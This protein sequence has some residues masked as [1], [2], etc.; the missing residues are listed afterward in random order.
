MY[1][2]ITMKL[3]VYFETYGCALNRADESVMKAILRDKGYEIVEDPK[4]AN[5]IVIN[6]CIVR[7]DTEVRMIKRLRYLAKLGKK[8]IVAGCMA[9]ALPSHV[10]RIVKEAILLAPQ[11]VSR[12][13]EAVE[14][15][16]A[17]M[18]I[19]EEKDIEYIGV[20]VEGVKA[21]IAVGEGCIDDCA[22]CIVKK[23][24]PR[25]K[26]IPIERVVKAVQ[27]ALSRG[28]KEIEITAQD[29]AVYGIDVYG[30]Y[31][32]VDLLN[33]ILELEYD[34][35]LR[36]GQLNPRHLIKYMDEI[37]EVLK[38]P[39]VYKHVHIPLQSGSNKVL[40]VMNRGSTVEE[41]IQIVHELRSKVEGI[42][43][44]TDIIVGH[45]GEDELSFLESVKVIAEYDIDRV[46][47]ARYSIR[48]FTP[49]ASMPQIPD[50]IK[51][52]RSKYIEKVYQLIALSKYLEYVNSYGVAVVTERGL[53]DD[54]FVARLFNYIP[55]VIKAPNALGKTLLIH[56][57]EATFYDLRGE[58]VKEVG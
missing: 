18:F 39:R 26:S 3:K 25:L 24:R 49:A 30:K 50:N 27:E 15:P 47:I 2:E 41:F 43:I 40:T 48:P 28:A 22:F 4:E 8:L 14:A 29:L 20:V 42:H 46:H 45:P 21:V 12:I 17:S 55:V 54:S 35:R 53:H 7:Y 33:A 13:H 1:V 10:R 37:V 11:S 9:R 32:L 6:T 38:D 34:F 5:V 57:K 23:A 56:I 44:A 19:E 52:I 51:K 16:P 31:A 58:V 36:I